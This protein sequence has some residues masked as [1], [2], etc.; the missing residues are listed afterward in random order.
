MA[1]NAGLFDVTDDV[2]GA[3]DAGPVHVLQAYNGDIL[4]IPGKAWLL[5][6]DFIPQGPDLLLTGTDGAQVTVRDFFNLDAPPDLVTESG[7]VISA[8]LAVKLAGPTAPGQFALVE[9]GPF[10]QLAQGAESIGT[11][12][13][14]DGVV[15]AIRIDGTKVPLAKGDDIF[16]GDT[17]VTGEGAAV[18]IVFVDET[19][20]SLGE[21]GRMVIDEMIYDPD[22]QEGA[23]G[24]TLVQG[25]FT[26]VSGE[27]AKTAPDAMTLSTPIA[28]IGIRGTKVAGRA[29]QEGEENTFSLLPEFDTAGNP[30]VGEVFIG[31]QG[32]NVVLNAFGATVQMTSAFD[33]PPPPIVFTQEQIQQKFGAALT[34]LS[35]VIAVKAQAD[36]E[37]NAEEAAQAA[38]DAEAAGAEAEAAA[39][40][41]EAAAAEAEAAAAEAAAALAAAE[42]SGD[43]AAL[44][45]AEAAVLA[46]EQAAA[47]AEAAAADAE[48]AA[49]EAEVA[50]ATAEAAV[51]EAAAAEA[52]AQFASAQFQ[53]QSQA[54]ADFGGGPLPGANDPSPLDGGPGDT[55]IPD[56]GGNTG[57]FGGDGDIFGGEGDG[58]LLGGLGLDALTEE[59]PIEDLIAEIIG[60][61]IDNII[62][63]IQDSFDEPFDFS[64]DIENVLTLEG[65]DGD[66][67]SD[68]D[69]VLNGTITDDV[70][71]GGDGNDQ[72]IMTQGSTLDGMDLVSGG[73]GTDE[74]AFR[75]MED[76]LGVFDAST[77][78]SPFIM[79]SESVGDSV[80]LYGSVDLDGIEQLYAD[81][82]VET[83]T[84]AAT[85]GANTGTNG[86]RLS[87]DLDS[88]ND[89]IPDESGFGY[90]WAGTNSGNDTFSLQ[91]TN[92]PT[93]FGD[94][95]HT[96]DDTQI[97]GSIMFGKGGN[98][99][100]TGSVA[101][102][103]IFGGTG[104]DIID[105][106]G[107]NSN[108]GDIL[109]GGAGNDTFNM[110]MSSLSST[111][112]VGGAGV[113]ILQ[114][115]S[116]GTGIDFNISST[117][118]TATH[119]SVVND[120]ITEVEKLT[121]AT[122]HSNSYTFTGDTTGHGLTDIF[123]DAQADTFTLS[124]GST[125][126]ANL[127]A[128]AGNDT[129]TIGSGATVSNA[130]ITGG[131]GNDT[132]TISQGASLSGSTSLTGSSGTN[133]FNVDATA[134][135][136]ATVAGGSGSSDTLNIIGSSAVSLSASELASVTLFETWSMNSSESYAVTLS[137][138]NAASGVK[139]TVDATGASSATLDASAETNGDLQ[140][141]GGS[142]TD[143]LTVSMAILDDGVSHVLD[144]NGGT[145]T[146]TFAGDLGGTLDTTEMSGIANF[147]TWILSGNYTYNMTLVDTNVTSGTTLTVNASTVTSAGVD[148]DG[149]AETNGSFNFIG[150][151]GND[152]FDGGSGADT[153]AGNNGNDELSGGG[154]G[155]TLTGGGGSDKFIYNMTTDG[156]A[157]GAVTGY[158]TIT[159][160]VSGQ[161][162]FHLDT[163]LTGAISDISVGG[164]LTWGTAGSTPVTLDFSSTKEA[165]LFN[166]SNGLTAADLI[167][168][169]WANV[170]TKINGHTIVAGDN[171]DA[172][173]AI[174]GGTHTGV[175]YYQEDVGG[176]SNSV[177]ASELTLIAVVQETIVD[178][179]FTA[180][181]GPA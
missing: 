10:V 80:G 119:D 8:E 114:Y 167:T 123:G 16:Q 1:Q 174:H 154:G 21:D 94:I 130:T 96:I 25:V 7:A 161:D 47:E 39:A 9:N 111:A 15:E 41:A 66:P 4:T 97:L 73:A 81:D 18:G 26:F 91:D 37:Q 106:G 69:Q 170:L 134:L 64:D 181:A 132:F 126:S 178:T 102:D 75:S 121:G 127:D 157:A 163:L 13:A 82:G 164:T 153:L 32:G 11:V 162:T 42:A 118:V 152:I 2:F 155:D 22:S 40:D 144:G 17:L 78:T 124:A 125:V 120:S 159:D 145:D 45:E 95:N 105:G 131:A 74:I 113:D 30:I 117:A 100:I 149:G 44:A 49:A 38:A 62:S 135:A 171:D 58:N 136:G 143:N 85:A 177:E 122:A 72:F 31:T 86:V 103:T 24:A 54:F 43:E 59:A 129:I 116:Y 70:L 151:G 83:Y 176:T 89:G 12:E 172:L 87:I 51:A 23:F 57:L 36:A 104:N 158:D 137:E 142:G 5:K 88:N 84:D 33:A 108:D 169:G 6:A 93:V 160:F 56:I 3:A 112:I 99:T 150:G 52:A 115:D 156:A 92:S 173:F 175:F 35:G 27:I 68:F 79:Y 46:A 141:T 180:T 76:I 61:I 71:V 98:D 179:D 55:G 109:I 165:V 34:T 133:T 14:T 63:D 148:V 128:E 29:G 67:T 147:E 107:T 168:S 28:T 50:A 90:I 60:D 166:S 53:A 138:N 146:L 140:Y 65:S 139:L 19:T 77:P 20:F 48:A 110:T 101:G